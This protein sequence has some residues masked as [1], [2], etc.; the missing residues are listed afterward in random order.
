VFGGGEGDRQ[1][2]R[3]TERQEEID[4]FPRKSSFLL[5]RPSTNWMRPN[6]TVNINLLNLNSADCTC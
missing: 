6:H 4:C 2:D 1:T 5:M 3:E